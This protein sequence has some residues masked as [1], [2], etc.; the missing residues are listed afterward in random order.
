M[1]R[2]RTRPSHA[3][4]RLE[5]GQCRRLLPTVGLT[6]LAQCA[7][8]PA[9]G[10]TVSPTSAP[11]TSHGVAA[12]PAFSA[13]EAAVSRE[14][15]SQSGLSTDG[16]GGESAMASPDALAPSGSQAE[17]SGPFASVAGAALGD[18]RVFGEIFAGSLNYPPKRLTWEFWRRG[19][20]V[21][22]EL[23]CELGRGP[24]VGA[25]GISIDGTEQDPGI[26]GPLLEGVV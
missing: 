25:M 11:A 22:L 20:R 15:V 9:S 17:I 1:N 13:D 10:A 7:A 8:A 12:V 18:R 24:R 4:D 5:G 14:T 16:G 6:A 2:A 21:R 19:G 23:S 26:W 3:P